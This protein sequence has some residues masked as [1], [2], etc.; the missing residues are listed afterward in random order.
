M[1]STVVLF[2]Q[3]FA[4]FCLPGCRKLMRRTAAAALTLMACA[5]SHGSP[6]STADAGPLTA[7]LS[8]AG[9]PSEG[10]GI[11]D[12]SVVYPLEAGS[13]ALAYSTVSP[14]QLHVHTRLALSADQGRS[15]TFGSEVNQAESASISTTDTT[16]CGAATC[17]GNLVHEVPSLV[18]DPG[19]S[20]DRLYKIFTHTYFANTAVG[21]A[22]SLHTDI[23]VLTLYTSA[24]PLGPWT[25]TQVIGWNGS[26][27][28]STQ[29]VQQNA[30]T[31]SALAGLARCVALTEPGALL[32][33]AIIDLAVGCAFSSNGQPQIEIDLLRSTDHARSFSFVAT[34]LSA[35]DA[36]SLGSAT[37]QINAPD[38]FQI[39]GQTYLFATPGGMVTF[40]GGGSGPGYRGCLTFT[41]SDIDAGTIARSGLGV[42]SVT[43]SYLGSPNQFIG[44]C[45]AAEGAPALG[46]AGDVL[47]LTQPLFGIFTTGRAAP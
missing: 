5:A 16:V 38:L 18:I 40:P 6:A 28:F 46:V 9:D 25:A 3:A 35:A 8:I 19:D 42:P 33:G 37:P 45:T 4:I 39:A 11:F 1:N 23:G 22:V 10:F 20:A 36:T 15:W 44:A 26:S 17:A 2:T 47:A 14:D 29:G 21:G 41:V 32:R 7:G 24:T 31:D 27:P 12:P 34:L 43:T 13:G 30:S